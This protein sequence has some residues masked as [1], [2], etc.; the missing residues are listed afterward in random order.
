L[1]ISQTINDPGKE[2]IGVHWITCFPVHEIWARSGL[3]AKT[4]GGRKNSHK[5]QD[6]YT[7]IQWEESKSSPFSFAL[8][9]SLGI[10][11]WVFDAACQYWSSVKAFEEKELEELE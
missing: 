9:L 5:R 2:R 1:T 11:P 4:M 6:R 3:M 7:P 8:G 10:V